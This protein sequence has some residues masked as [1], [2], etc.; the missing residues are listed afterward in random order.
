MQLINDVRSEG[1]A[2]VLSDWAKEFGAAHDALLVL[3]I[4][5]REW[6]S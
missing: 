6:H 2:G 5:S 3:K 4:R 1:H